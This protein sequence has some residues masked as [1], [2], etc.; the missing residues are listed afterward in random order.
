MNKTNKVLVVVAHPDDELLGLAGTLCK[1]R[2]AG[3]NVSILILANGEDSRDTG[4]NAKKRLGQ[5][6]RVAK[7]LKAKLY[8][9]NLPDNQFDS[10]PLLKIAK[11][12]EKVI[13]KVKP[14]IV[15][16]HHPQ[17]LNIDH[18]KACEAVM[19]ACRPMPGVHV[20]KIFG[21]ETLSSTEWQIKDFRQFAPN[22]YVD[23]HKY[24]KEKRSLLKHYHDEMRNY[25]HS[26]S[27]EGVEILAKYRGLEVGLKSAEAFEVL[28]S[29]DF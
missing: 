6:G 26:R 29:I 14:S 8:L 5:A 11:L 23:I 2:D 1:H 20:R 10:V 25:P 19:T 17:D 9:E 21:F 4:A 24:L 16:T 28:R 13:F 27:Y 15:Y 7:K 3:D 18:Q 22:H 12:V